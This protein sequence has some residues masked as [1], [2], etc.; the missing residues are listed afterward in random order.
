MNR[1][2]INNLG[3]SL[4]ELIVA[5]VV[6]SIGTIAFITLVL[7]T[8]QNSIDPQVRVQG[9]AIARAYLEEIMLTQFCDPDW[10]RN[11]DADADPL[12]NPT[13]CAVDCSAAILGA[14]NASACTDCSLLGNGW[15]AEARG[16]FDDVCDY[17][18]LTDV[19]AVDQTGTAI[20][21]LEDYTVVV[22]L[23]DAAAVDLNGLAG[24]D[25]QVVRV[26]VDVT[27]TTGATMSLSSYKT[28]Y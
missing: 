13:V 27:H 24:D 1:L 12:T 10:D 20:V 9:N 18:G 8:T 15:G 25:G 21:G 4:I 3:F 7:N 16:T 23:N 17:Q 14:G 26:D 11:A 19:G 28:N 6:L 22:T 2:K 5:I